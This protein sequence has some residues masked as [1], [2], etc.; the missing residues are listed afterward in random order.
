MIKT[1]LI[2]GTILVWIAIIL[3]AFGAHFLKTILDT[4]QLAS[5]E[6]G[7]RYQLIQGIAIIVLSLNSDKFKFPLKKILNSMIIGLCLF[8]FS[9][10]LLVFFNKIGLH[11]PF[12]GLLT[13]IGG[14]IL[15]GSWIYLTIC[16]LRKS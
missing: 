10:Y 6:T 8:S 7:I 13:P 15:I 16:L 2:L 1:S 12:L 14:V 9:I 3:G 5:I 11:I 4:N